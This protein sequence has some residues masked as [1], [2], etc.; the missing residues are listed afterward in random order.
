MAAKKPAKSKGV[1]TSKTVNSRSSLTFAQ[2]N[3]Y[4]AAYKA[5]IKSANQQA[6][7]NSIAQSRIQ[8]ASTRGRARN[9]YVTRS[10]SQVVRNTYLQARYGVQ[11]YPFL[12]IPLKSRL[13]SKQS[14]TAYI[15]A[16]YG[17]KVYAMTR[18]QSSVR[19]QPWAQGKVTTAAKSAVRKP[20]TSRTKYASAYASAF[21]NSVARRVPASQ[22]AAFKPR[23]APRHLAAVPDT[24]W[25]TAG[26]D[27]GA[28]NC[29][30]VAIGNS[31]LYNFGYRVTD[32]QLELVKDHKLNRA[33]WKI[34]HD[35]PWW[36]VE[37]AWYRW[38]DEPAPG[39]II[40]FES[41]NGPHCGILLPG[42][43]VVSWG[44][45]IPLESEIEEAWTLK[46]LT[47]G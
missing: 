24:P 34:W 20:Q 47:T 21:A 28:E 8:A 14:I 43:K 17:K 7:A 38:T 46:W 23:K 41:E 11:R 22:K 37:L 9:R 12:G 31:L 16:R 30:A 29:V 27:E 32:E 26:N 15:Q 5:A 10:Q 6:R 2:R 36:P 3:V 18:P 25:I 40:G 39:D 1:K 35:E 45:V 19:V 44:E 4:Q 13:V 33:L 42:N